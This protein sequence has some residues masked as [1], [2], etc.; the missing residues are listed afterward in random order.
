MIII[1]G[2]GDKM[3]SKFIKRLIDIILSLIALLLLW[4]V[5]IVIAILIKKEDKG[6][7]F[8][9]QIRT[10]KNG[11][12]FEMFKFRSMN[13]V[14]R[15]KEMTIKHEQRVTK[16]GKF[17]RKTSLDEL[18]QFLNVLK[19]DMS[20]I[21]PRPWIVEYYERFNEEQ[22]KRVDVR[23]GIIGLAQAKGRNGLTIFEKIKYDLEYVNNL[24]FIMDVKIIIE[25]VK[26]VLKKEHAEI[27][28]EDIKT[29]LK[30]L[31]AQ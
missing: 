11:K 9:K 3:Y 24:S 25:S 12:N 17:L 21:G 2:K 13:V 18:P 23:P 28:Q 6:T 10:G 5:F 27:N 16:I 20:F 14:E 4:P 26:I 29:E 1:D 7:V 15:G 19:G 30:Q 8:Y 31:E 22:K